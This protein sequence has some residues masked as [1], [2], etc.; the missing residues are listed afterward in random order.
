MQNTH[1][2]YHSGDERPC[3]M[4]ITNNS[5]SLTN[6]TGHVSYHD[7]KCIVT[8]GSKDCRKTTSSAGSDDKVGITKDGRES[9]PRRLLMKM[10]PLCA[11]ILTHLLILSLF[12][13]VQNSC[14]F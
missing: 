13:C 7:V 1:Q 3:A 8:G 12:S 2:I 14:N 11:Q 10:V 6:N 9:A 4:Y 5:R